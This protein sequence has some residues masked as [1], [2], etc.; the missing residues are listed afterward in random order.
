MEQVNAATFRHQK[1]IGGSRVLGD[2]SLSRCTCVGSGIAQF[3]D[4]GFGLVVQGVEARRCRLDN[5][6]AHGVLFRD[7]LVEDLSVAGGLHLEACVFE[8][9]TLRGNIRGRVMTTPPNYALA[10]EV[11]KSFTAAMRA[12]YQEVEWALDIREAKFS[13]AD[14][15]YV[16]GELIRR[17]EETQFLLRR[18]SFSRVDLSELPVYAGIAAGRFEVSPWDSIVAVAPRRSKNFDQWV[19]ELSEL[20]RMG[21]AE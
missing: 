11:Q 3:D 2:A 8:R 17:D 20:R 16:P 7:V 6:S 18:E 14:F 5:C 4:P 19:S 15:Y 1:I 12:I 9:V 10:E 21:L 13:D